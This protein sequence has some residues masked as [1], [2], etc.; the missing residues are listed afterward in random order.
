MDS[1]DFPCDAQ[2][3]VTQVA[4][5]LP[6][7]QRS[8]AG[9]SMVCSEAEHAVILSITVV[10]VHE[11]LSSAG[12]KKEISNETTMWLLVYTFAVRVAF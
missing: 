7:A 11:T 12:P 2:F 6:V 8:F 5:L 9:A 10:A 1:P 4:R 3:N